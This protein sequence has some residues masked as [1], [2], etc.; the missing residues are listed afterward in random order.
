[1]RQARTFWN[2]PIRS[3]QWMLRTIAQYEGDLD[4]LVPSGIYEPLTQIA[5]SK[6]QRSHGLPVTGIT[7]YNTWNKVVQ[8][9]DEAIIMVSPAQS[10]DPE[11]QAVFPP[12]EGRYSPY[13]H[14]A[15]CMLFFLANFYHGV[16]Q[17]E[18]TGY[19]NATTRQS[20]GD[21]QRLCALPMTGKLDKRTWKYLAIHFAAASAWHDKS[22]TG[23]NSKNVHK[24]L[25][26]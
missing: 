3:L 10:I 18:T 16:F 5:V 15:Q 17:P 26:K 12:A 25:D 23:S 19:M 2:Q 11:Y 8:A 14:L 9:Y 20:L 7:D 6:F 13:L 22:S 1:M 4:V 21:F 24:E